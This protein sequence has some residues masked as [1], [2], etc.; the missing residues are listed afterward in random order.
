MPTPPQPRQRIVRV[1]GHDV[2]KT[3]SSN[4]AMATNKLAR[5]LQTP[6]VT[7]VTTMLKAT[8]CQVNEIHQD[9]RPS[10]STTSIRRSA[11]TRT[12]RR[13]SRFTD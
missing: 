5:L 13:Q 2:Y 3:P 9:Q 12:D 6:K 1:D 4:L 8:H 11:V 7:K 10:Y